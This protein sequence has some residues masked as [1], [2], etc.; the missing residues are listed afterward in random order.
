[1]KLMSV[2][3]C[4]DTRFFDKKAAFVISENGSKKMRLNE[5]VLLQNFD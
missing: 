3:L 5:F 4:T 1:M 2:S